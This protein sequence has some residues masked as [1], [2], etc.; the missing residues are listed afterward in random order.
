MFLT[1]T[2]K[3]AISKYMPCFVRTAYRDPMNH[4]M[5]L[6]TSLNFQKISVK[7]AAIITEI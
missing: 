2:Q 7:V 5:C 3:I 1:E 4:L 6:I